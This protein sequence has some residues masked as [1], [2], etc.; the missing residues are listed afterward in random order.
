MLLGFACLLGAAYGAVHDQI[1]YTVAPEYFH[2][3]KFEQFWIDPAF[4]NRLGAAIVGVRA[5]W[6]MGLLIGLPIGVI[7]LFARSHGDFVRTF[8]RAAVVVVATTLLMGLGALGYAFITLSADNLPDWVEGWPLTDPVAFARAGT[9]H[10]F[11][12]LGGGL[13]LIAGIVVM[14]IGVVASRRK[15]ANVSQE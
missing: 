13:G 1:S 7:G 10:N 2:V 4:H 14:L 3:F 5:S 12:Y 11:S 8:A 6:W 15:S 9:M